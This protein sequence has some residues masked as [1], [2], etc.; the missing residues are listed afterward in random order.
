[1][2]N[3]NEFWTEVGN[4]L[5]SGGLQYK[6]LADG[7][8]TTKQ[9]V[10]AWKTR[11]QIPP[12]LYVGGIAS[13]FGCSIEALMGLEERSFEGILNIPLIS[14]RLSCGSGEHWDTEVS[15]TSIS[16]ME[17]LASGQKKESLVAA[18][19]KGDSMIGA[20]LFD[21][22]MVVFSRGLVSGNG[23]Y[24][25]A[26]DGEVYVKRLAWNPI[27]RVITIISE[28]P[29]YAPMTVNMDDE[30]LIILGKVTGW[31]HTSR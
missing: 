21:G 29:A 10:S 1:M 15:S 16:I 13:F 2:K 11:D 3:G 31:L 4:R 30:R 19:V 8:G 27:T 25:I 17:R 5:A 24:A 23:I 14:Q 20:S 12:V 9:Q 6:D 28:N 18:I 7:I 22:D 26:I